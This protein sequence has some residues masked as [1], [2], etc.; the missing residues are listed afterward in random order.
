MLNASLPSS[1]GG[2]ESIHLASRIRQALSMGSFFNTLPHVLSY[3]RRQTLLILRYDL[4][5]A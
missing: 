2:D 4:W 1:C 3:T 5:P